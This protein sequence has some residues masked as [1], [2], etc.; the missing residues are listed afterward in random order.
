MPRLFV[1]THL[2][3]I[4]EN[5]NFLAFAFLLDSRQHLSPL[6]SRRADSYPVVIGNK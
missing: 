5:N 4:P 6:N 1:V 3:L 2:R